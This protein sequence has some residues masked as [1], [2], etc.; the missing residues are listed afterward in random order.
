MELQDLYKEFQGT[1][2]VAEKIEYLRTM[3]RMNLPY[4]INWQGLIDG[5]LAAATAA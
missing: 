1:Y 2:S 5:W 3:E 4:D